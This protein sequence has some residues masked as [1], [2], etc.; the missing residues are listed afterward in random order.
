M[1]L[2]AIHGRRCHAAAA[3]GPPQVLQASSRAAWL[4]VLHWK[5]GW[6][7]AG[8]Y[9]SVKVLYALGAGRGAVVASRPRLSVRPPEN[10]ACG[11]PAVVQYSEGR[12]GSKYSNCKAPGWEQAAIFPAAALLWPQQD[13]AGRLRCCRRAGVHTAIISTSNMASAVSMRCSTVQTPKACTSA[14][15]QQQIAP[16]AGLRR[17]NVLYKESAACPAQQVSRQGA[18]CQ[19]EQDYHCK[20]SAQPAPGSHMPR[21]HPGRPHK[22]MGTA[23]CSCAPVPPAAALP[24]VALPAAPPS[25]QRPWPPR[26]FSCWVSGPVGQVAGAAPRCSQQGACRGRFR[27]SQPCRTNGATHLHP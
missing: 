21:K 10:C 3:A 26:R 13:V 19:A 16:F 20:R 9:F 8:W 5:R 7:H 12:R 24:P 4:A 6:P 2:A 23:R 14:L 15:S 1:P 17:I 18:N 22:C 25:C 11:A 27:S